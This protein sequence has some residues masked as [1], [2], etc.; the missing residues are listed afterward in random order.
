VTIQRV[1]V[2][3]FVIVALASALWWFVFRDAGY[4]GWSDV[5]G[6]EL[7]QCA[8]ESCIELAE[9]DLLHSGKLTIRY[10]ADLDDGVTEWASCVQALLSCSD[11]DNIDGCLAIDEC[12]TECLQRL[13]E[14]EGVL[15]T[16]VSFLEAVNSEFL[17][18]SAYCGVPDE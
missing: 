1:G 8:G 18:D 17:A 9:L 12:P 4:S 2:F 14:V 11:E 6:A 13:S 5:A 3:L 7:E 15:S 16:H 10:L